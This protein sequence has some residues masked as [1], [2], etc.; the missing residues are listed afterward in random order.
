MRIIEGWTKEE[1]NALET[2]TR[3]HRT[4]RLVIEFIKSRRVNNS[5]Q[6]RFNSID[7]DKDDMQFFRDI[8]DYCDGSAAF[9]IKHAFK[10]KNVYMGCNESPLY[11]EEFKK[12]HVN[13]TNDIDFALRLTDKE[14]IERVGKFRFDFN[15]FEPAEELNDDE[16]IN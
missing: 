3:V 5:L 15:K 12:D 6:D 9:E 1:R 10:L 2:L 7:N 13:L 11:V 14:F 4:P 16:E 8:V